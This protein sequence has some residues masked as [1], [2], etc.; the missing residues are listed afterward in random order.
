MKGGS[1]LDLFGEWWGEQNITQSTDFV[2]EGGLSKV[3]LKEWEVQ[4]LVEVSKRQNYVGGSS[5]K[6]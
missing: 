3:R 5:A 4:L 1:D 2:R 6:K